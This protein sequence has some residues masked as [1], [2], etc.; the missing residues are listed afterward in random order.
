[1]QRAAVGEYNQY[2]TPRWA[3][4]VLPQAGTNRENKRLGVRLSVDST[5]IAYH[6][7]IVNRPT[8]VP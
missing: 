8:W 4:I 2:L 1:M 5:V 3:V 7:V 6:H